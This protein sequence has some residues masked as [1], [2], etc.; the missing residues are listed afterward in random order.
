MLLVKI[1]LVL[2]FRML[3]HPVSPLLYLDIFPSFILISFHLSVSHLFG[4]PQGS[5]LTHRFFL[6]VQPSHLMTICTIYKLTN[7]ETWVSELNIHKFH[8]F[9]YTAFWIST[10]MSKRHLKLN[11]FKNDSLDPPPSSSPAAG[12]ACHLIQ[13]LGVILH[14]PLFLT[15]QALKI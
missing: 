13:K 11:M 1:L 9:I 2:G 6:F 15:P 10:K 5:V 4:M 12:L 3:L 14:K 8:T 7:S